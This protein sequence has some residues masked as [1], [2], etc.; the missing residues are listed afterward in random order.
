MKEEETL[1]NATKKNHHEVVIVG[2]EKIT[3]FFDERNRL[4]FWM[5]K[6]WNEEDETP[7]NIA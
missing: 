1:K 7:E 4:H 3:Q 5:K 6:E 2:G